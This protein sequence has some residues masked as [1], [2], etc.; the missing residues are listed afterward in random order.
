VA[1]WGEVAGDGLGFPDSGSDG[2]GEGSCKRE[3]AAWAAEERRR[4]RVAAVR[5]VLV[6]VGDHEC[7]GSCEREVLLAR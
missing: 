2:D 5:V 1:N 4:A 7:G 6:S 3:P